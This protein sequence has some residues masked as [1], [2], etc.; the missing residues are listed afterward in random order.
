MTLSTSD[1]AA[2][3]DL[4]NRFGHLIDDGDFDRLTELFTADVTYDVSDLGFGVIRGLTALR[5]GALALGD[6]NPVG[7]HVTNVVITPTEGGEVRAL[8]KGLGVNADGTT[9]S[10]T[11]ED[12]IIRA[13]GGWRI[14]H[15]VLRARRTPLTR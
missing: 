4:I 11:Y 10:A 1:R 9:R 12:T 3:T 7:H 2:I 13:D 6:G 5:E 8:S 15:R 14:S